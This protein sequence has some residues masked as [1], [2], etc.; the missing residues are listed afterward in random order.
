M[1]GPAQRLLHT[2]CTLLGIHLLTQDLES[3]IDCAIHDGRFSAEELERFELRPP[4]VRLASLGAVS[5]EA[6]TGATLFDFRLAAVA[7]CEDSERAPRGEAARL[8]A[9]RICFELARP[10]EGGDGGDMWA[11]ICFSPAELDPNRT[12]RPRWGDIGEPREIRSANLYSAKLDE[13]LAALWAVTWTQK[14]RALPSDF[15]I[16][17]PAPAGIP[18]AVLS[19]RA[20]EIG[21]EH[22][23]GYEL[24]AGDLERVSS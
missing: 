20:P 13:S 2:C 11:R 8:L 22:E 5:A 17:L 1:T 15:D 3:N 16:D 19:A 12:D 23:S 4:S 7:V 14:F 24:A 21:E 10:Q 18:K 9:D 6:D